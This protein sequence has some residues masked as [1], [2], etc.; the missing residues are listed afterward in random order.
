M[1]VEDDVN[2]GAPLD[3]DDKGHAFGTDDIMAYRSL[4]VQ[5]ILSAQMKQPNKHEVVSAEALVP[6]LQKKKAS[7]ELVKA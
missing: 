3:D 4:T 2:E 6:A 1:D 5:K 7:K